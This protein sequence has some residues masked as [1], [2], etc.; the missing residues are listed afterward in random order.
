MVLFADTSVSVPEYEL[1]VKFVGSAV[2]V[3]VAGVAK[4]PAGGTGIFN[5]G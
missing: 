5:Q 2:I 1:D 4:P 3:S